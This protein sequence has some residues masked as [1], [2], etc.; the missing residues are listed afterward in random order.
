[1]L[2]LAGFLYFQPLPAA[3]Y[4]QTE[5]AIF[6]GNGHG[7]ISLNY[8]QHFIQSPYGAQLQ[9]LHQL[10]LEL[11]YNLVRNV[12]ASLEWSFLYVENYSLEETQGA[13]GDLEVQ[14]FF[15]RDITE[16]QYR[17]AYYW[18][19]R[20]SGGAESIT[21]ESERSSVLDNS[22]KTSFYP[23]SVPVNRMSLGYLLS[24]NYSD[25]LQFS[26]DFAYHYELKE[27]ESAT[28]FLA[29]QGVQNDNVQGGEQDMGNSYSLFG[30]D[31]SFRKLFWRTSLSD[32]FEDK[33]NDHLQV[34]AAIDTT[35]Y[36]E[37]HFPE[38]NVAFVS[39]PFL[40][41]VYFHPIS[42]ESFQAQAFTLIPGLWFKI[43]ERYKFKLARSITL[44]KE[45]KSDIHK[46][47]YF[48]FAYA[49]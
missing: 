32:P 18:G 2:L 20:R 22:V 12:M 41:F 31:E 11:R 6:L 34:K 8:Q 36:T 7:E 46:S 48:Y 13:T 35:F 24:K 39:R 38:R 10:P 29:F 15:G 14:I 33:K 27:D 17:D 37:Y 1:M 43:G 25:K 47:L 19:F 40:E 3:P 16:H 4:T 28:N 21:E 9:K 45:N 5:D 42:E 49:I 44:Y 23:L 26:L 30:L